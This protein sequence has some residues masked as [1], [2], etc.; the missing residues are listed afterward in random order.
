MA[1]EIIVTYRDLLVAKSKGLFEDETL[2]PM[3][4]ISSGSAA[5][6]IQSALTEF[7]LPDLKVLMDYKIDTS[8]TEHL[9]SMG[10]EVYLMDLSLKMLDA[11]EILELTNNLQ[12]NDI[13]SST[14]L[15]PNQRFYD[16]LSYEIINESPDYCFV[17]Y[18]SGTLFTNLL[19]INKHEVTTIVPDPRFKGDQE[20]TAHCHFLGA[21]TSNPSTQADKLWSPFLPFGISDLQWLKWY[22]NLG[23]CGKLS[24]IYPFQEKYL[25]QA[26]K[27]FRKNVIEAE[28]SGMAGLALLL[29]MQDSVP[30]D[31]KVMIVNTGK[32]KF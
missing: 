19:N 2:P 12:G 7:E 18:G 14:A 31:A 23:Y 29:Q 16:W 27:I 8:I 22:R 3:S 11:P 26:I 32:L 5:I 10:A 21:A 17:P 4:L 25:D 9:E 1:W 30:A 6:A 13:T 15:D 24:G 20:T 28:P